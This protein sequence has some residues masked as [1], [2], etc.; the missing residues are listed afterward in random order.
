MAIVSR[1]GGGGDVGGRTTSILSERLNAP[2][3]GRIKHENPLTYELYGPG[4]VAFEILRPV[5]RD[6][7]LHVLDAAEVFEHVRQVR[8]HVQHILCSNWKDD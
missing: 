8:S 6:R 1:G 7:D 3:T 4:E 2:F 5:V